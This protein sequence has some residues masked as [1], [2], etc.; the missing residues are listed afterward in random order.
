MRSSFVEQIVSYDGSQLESHW[1]LKTAGIRGDA[2][3]SF[4]GP[5]KVDLTHMVDL[6]DVIQKK[7]I[8]S[9]NMLHFIVEHFDP[10][11][12]KMILRQRLLVSLIQHEWNECLQGERVV[13][14]GDDLFLGENKLTVSIATRSPVSCL[15]HTGVNISSQNTP[16]P[17][18]GLEDFDL[19]PQA[20]ATSVMNRYVEEMEGVRW[21]G[22]K[23]RG[24][25]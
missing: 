8:F 12:E 2:I 15:I 19:N 21:A 3:V 5:A 4:T 13:R 1:I 17:T 10:D 23:V 16:L 6:E 25:R 7:P 22:C 14:S 9:E 11:L 20:F 18:K 24:V